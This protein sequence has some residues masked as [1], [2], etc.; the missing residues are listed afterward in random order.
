VTRLLLSAVW[1]CAAAGIVAAAAPE[2][3][4]YIHPPPESALD[5]RY[6]FEWKILE[7]AL[8]RTRATHGAYVIESSGFMTERRQVHELTSG[9]GKLTILFLGTSP[10]MERTLWPIRI[11]VDSICR[12]TAF[13]IENPIAALC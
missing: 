2:P 10:E 3:M 7:T 13:L 8:E 12:A 5:H 11:P 1:L 4:R 6:D 9:S